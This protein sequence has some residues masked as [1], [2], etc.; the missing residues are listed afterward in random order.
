MVTFEF[1][2]EEASNNGGCIL[3]ERP[4]S[5][6]AVGLS[7]DGQVPEP[8]FILQGCVLGTTLSE[9]FEKDIANDHPGAFLEEE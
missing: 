2:T 1:V 8:F 5:P 6:G 3:V 7:R 9:Q 4:G